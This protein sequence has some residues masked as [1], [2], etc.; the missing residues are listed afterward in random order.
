M[1]GWAM[2]ERY[3]WMDGQCSTGLDGWMGNARELRV[4][5]LRRRQGGGVGVSGDLHGDVRY[6]SGDTDIGSGL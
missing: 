3:G 4:V 6:S 5:S 1:D 2:L